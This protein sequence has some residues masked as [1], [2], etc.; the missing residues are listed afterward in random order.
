MMRFHRIAPVGRRAIVLQ[1][2]VASL[3][4]IADIV[5]AQMLIQPVVVELAPRQ[6]AVA[7]SVTLSE[8]APAPVRLQAELLRWKQDPEGHSITAPSDDLI[9][10]PPLADLQPGQRQVFRIALRGAPS[11]QELAYRLVLEDIADPDAA[12]SGAPGMAINFRMR[13]DLP[14]LVAPAGKIQNA[15]RWSA[16]ATAVAKLAPEAVP[17][18]AC[19]RLLNAGNRRVKVQMLTL[20]GDGWQQALMIKDGENV[21]VGSEREWHVPLATGQSGALRGVQV[22][23][24]RGETLQAEAGSY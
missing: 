3:C 8:T 9:V 19:V 22:Q 20:S 24:V 23:T 18:E 12:A 16:C 11:N 1:G 2:C 5:Q 10:S 13:Y 17:A 6:R 21:L 14:V 15:L 4:L 7:I